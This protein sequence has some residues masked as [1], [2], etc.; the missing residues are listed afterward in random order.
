M[1]AEFNWWLLVVGV[2]AGAGLVS[3]V[4]GNWGRGSDASAADLDDEAAWITGALGDQGTTLAPDTI[5]AILRL[6]GTWLTGD[7]DAE[8]PWATDEEA[9]GAAEPDGE[10]R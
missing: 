1:N 8:D 5:A 2:V 9:Y 7:G 4:A 6:H 10:G 3:L